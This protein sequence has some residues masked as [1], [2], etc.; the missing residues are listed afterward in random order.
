MFRIGSIVMGKKKEIKEEINEK[1]CNC[2]DGDKCT[3]GDNCHCGDDCKCGVNCQCRKNKNYY[4]KFF[5]VSFI[6]LVLF[7]G[8]L[9]VGA[10]LL[11]KNDDVISEKCGEEQHVVQNDANINLPVEQYFENYYGWKYFDFFSIEKYPYDDISLKT[12]EDIEY[13]INSMRYAVGSDVDSLVR[14]NFFDNG[15]DSED[16]KKLHIFME[17]YVL[18]ATIG[19]YADSM[20]SL[21][22]SEDIIMEEMKKVFAIEDDFSLVSFEAIPF[23][24][25]YPMLSCFSGI[26]IAS[27][28]QGGG[29]GGFKHYETK[30]VDSRKNGSNTIYTLDD[31]YYEPLFDDKDEFTGDYSETKVGTYEMTF[32]K[33][34]RYVSSKKIN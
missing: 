29:T 7:L 20:D 14:K 4:L 16:L 3:C 22:I 34:N 1:H 13:F 28:G 27:V 30:I 12:E 10:V 17:A 33:D 11:Y 9:I 8:G 25:N 31:Y 21:F 18:R 5:V 23:N 6:G 32:D 2:K 24:W 26:C 15:N 19:R